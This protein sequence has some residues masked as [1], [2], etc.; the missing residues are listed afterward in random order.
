MATEKAV[1]TVLKGIE[2]FDP[3]VLKHTE[4]QEKVVLPDAEGKRS[5]VVYPKRHIYSKYVFLFY[6]WDSQWRSLSVWKCSHHQL[7]SVHELKAF[8]FKCFV[9]SSSNCLFVLF[10][11]RPTREDAAEFASW[12]WVIRQ[13]CLE[14]NWYRR[15]DYSSRYGR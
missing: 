5:V 6:W 1:E 2:D 3:S 8:E 9:N 4:T 12:C 13:V 11:S 15:E 10:S 14:A 7:Y